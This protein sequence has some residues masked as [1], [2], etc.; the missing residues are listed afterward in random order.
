MSKWHVE[1]PNN[2]HTGG[3]QVRDEQNVPI[4]TMRGGLREQEENAR[5]IVAAHNGDHAEPMEPLTADQIL[6]GMGL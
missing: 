6:R 3:W 4:C 5:R 2:S 1:K